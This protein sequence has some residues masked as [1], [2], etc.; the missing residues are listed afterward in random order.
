MAT[1]SLPGIDDGEVGTSF[2]SIGHRI[3]D[4][5]H[6]FIRAIEINCKNCIEI[7][8]KILQ[9]ALREEQCQNPA[10]RSL[11]EQFEQVITLCELLQSLCESAW[12]IPEPRRINALRRLT[13][14]APKV[15]QHFG[16]VWKKMLESESIVRV[17]KR[18]P[19]F[20]ENLRTLEEMVDT[21]TTNTFFTQA[22]ASL[23]PSPGNRAGND[24]VQSWESLGLTWPE[25]RHIESQYHR[26]HEDTQHHQEQ[27]TPRGQGGA[28][29]GE[30]PREPSPDPCSDDT[31][32]A[33]LYAFFIDCSKIFLQWLKGLIN[34]C[35]DI[36][37][38][39]IS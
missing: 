28:R 11:R 2:D 31:Y 4:N 9:H 26:Q 36:Y 6:E 30:P 12:D 5:T 22:T 34:S 38:I 8:K 7:V 17:L 39:I 25:E 10:A 32:L 3:Y 37:T 33:R 19:G 29:N 20:Q 35:N 16:R 24:T 27:E 1:R 15:G 18:L 14:M 23:A 13:A 21:V